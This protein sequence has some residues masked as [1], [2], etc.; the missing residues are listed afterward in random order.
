MKTIGKKSLSS[1]IATIVNIVWW[2]EWIA[3]SMVLA[4]LIGMLFMEK[5]ISLKVPVSFSPFTMPKSGDAAANTEGSLT[6]M[7]GNFTFPIT[8]NFQNAALLFLLLAATLTIFLTITYQL[9]VIFS[10]LKQNNP[11]DEHNIQRIKNIGLIL[12]L[13]AFFHFFFNIFIVHYLNTHFKVD[14]V[15]LTSKF[16]FSYLAIGMILII[17]AEVFRRGASLEQENNLTI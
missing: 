8:V 9:K 7:D 12:M 2:I 3:G 16:N 15:A 6:V 10:N 1:V 13:S 5:T 11:F 14:S 17:V 4:V